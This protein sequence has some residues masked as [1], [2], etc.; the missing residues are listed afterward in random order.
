LRRAHAAAILNEMAALISLLIIILVSIIVVRIGATA[1]ELTGLSAD[2]ATF[3]AQSAFSGAGFTTQEAEAMLTH[4]VR[5]RIIRLLILLGSARLVSTI[6]TLVLSFVGE[7]GST[8]LFRGGVLLGGLLVIYLLA[9]SKYIERGMKKLIAGALKRL[10]GVHL[11]DYETLLGLSEGYDI[12]R[13]EIKDDSWMSDRKL[14]ELRLDR[15]GALVLAIYRGGPDSGDGSR[16]IGAPVGDTELRAGDQLVCYAPQSV[17]RNLSDRLKGTG[18][19]AEHESQ[20]RE[21]KVRERRGV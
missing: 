17:S 5:R 14:R 2:I 16:F 20:V 21:Q 18:G 13:I 3:Q 4:P 11:V 7:S 6:A 15:E 10:T 1:L 8:V 12:C 19:D 9:R